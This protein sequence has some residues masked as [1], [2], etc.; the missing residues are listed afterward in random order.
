MY[1]ASDSVKTEEPVAENERDTYPRVIRLPGRDEH[2]NVA[3]MT[4]GERIDAA[5]QLTLDAWAFM[6]RSDEAEAP[7]RRNVTR[8]VRRER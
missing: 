3:E 4:P 8:V 5:W 6:G 1:A 2:R 7:L